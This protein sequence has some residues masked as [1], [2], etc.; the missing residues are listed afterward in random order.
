MVSGWININKVFMNVN[1]D[2][3]ENSPK[4]NHKACPFRDFGESASKVLSPKT[5]F[6]E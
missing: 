1:F 2:I 5:D 6:E 3:L 4:P